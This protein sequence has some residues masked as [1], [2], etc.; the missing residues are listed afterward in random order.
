M[1]AAS[2]TEIVDFKMK[3]HGRGA[4]RLIDMDPHGRILRRGIS[5]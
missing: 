1:R 3:G 5:K 2:S 4:R